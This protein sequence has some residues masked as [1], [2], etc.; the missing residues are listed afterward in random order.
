MC[1]CPQHRGY[2]TFSNWPD[3]IATVKC[4]AGEYVQN[5][6]TGASVLNEFWHVQFGTLV[7]DLGV[8]QSNRTATVLREETCGWGLQLSG[9]CTVHHEPCQDLY[10]YTMFSLSGGKGIARY[11]NDLNLV[12]PI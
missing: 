2:E 1:R 4:Q 5:K 9:R 11:Y 8:A 3:C 12:S 10:D 6:C 7:R